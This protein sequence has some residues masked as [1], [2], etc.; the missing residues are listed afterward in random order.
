[1]QFDVKYI[2]EHAKSSAIPVVF[3][4]LNQNHQLK[5]LKLGEVK[6]GDAILSVHDA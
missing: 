6:A 5:L 1:M 2:E 4:N 3:T